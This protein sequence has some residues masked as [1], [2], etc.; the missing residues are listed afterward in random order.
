MRLELFL[1][2]VLR[3][4]KKATRRSFYETTGTCQAQKPAAPVPAARNR[5]FSEGPRPSRIRLFQPVPSSARCSF[6]VRSSPWMR[7]GEA[8]TNSELRAINFSHKQSRIPRGI[9]HAGHLRPGSRRPAVRT[10][11]EVG[12]GRR[13]GCECEAKCKRCKALDHEHSGGKNPAECVRSHPSEEYDPLITP[14]ANSRVTGVWP[15][16]YRAR[17]GG[18]LCITGLEERSAV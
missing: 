10:G 13:C 6:A 12:T 9:G 4:E 15:R 8:R 18:S 7:L 3:V 2:I 17:T 5:F 14:L 1:R 11:G 16:G